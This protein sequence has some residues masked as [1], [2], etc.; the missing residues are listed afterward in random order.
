[1]CPNEFNGLLSHGGHLEKY[2]LSLSPYPRFEEFS[3][4]AK[5]GRT[6]DFILLELKMA[7]RNK[8]PWPCIAVRSV[9]PLSKMTL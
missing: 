8:S 3:N 2:P 4:E 7:S 9:V 1:M 6:I 5:E